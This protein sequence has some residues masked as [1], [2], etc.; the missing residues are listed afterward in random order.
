MQL[1]VFFSLF[2]LPNKTRCYTS[3]LTSQQIHL[4][5]KSSMDPAVELVRAR[6][7]LAVVLGGRGNAVGSGDRLLVVAWGGVD[8]CAAVA[9]LHRHGWVH[10]RR[11]VPA[12]QRAAAL[13]VHQHRS[14]DEL[15][16][17]G[18]AVQTTCVSI[19]LCRGGGKRKGRGYGAGWFVCVLAGGGR[20]R[21]W[22]SG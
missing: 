13:A 22:R 21:E 14:V 17:R 5:P 10:R 3:P 6:L 4:F 20:T 18:D 1:C 7:S 12:A 15:R 8:I 19:K 9:R 2:V 16:D 11:V